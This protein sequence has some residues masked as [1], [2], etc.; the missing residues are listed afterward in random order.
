MIYKTW[1]IFKPDKNIFLWKL[2]SKCASLNGNEEKIKSNKKQKS[3]TLS[4]RFISAHTEK[5][6][7]NVIKSNRN[8]IIFT[9]FRFIW[10]KT[11]TVCLVPNQSNIKSI[12]CIFNYMII[13]RWT[14]LISNIHNRTPKIRILFTDKGLFS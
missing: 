4:V 11:D 5:C 3:R 14:M 2:T 7:R 1:M 10:N 13:R 12:L 6:F 8:Y 9:I